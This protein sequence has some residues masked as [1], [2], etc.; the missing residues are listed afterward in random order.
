MACRHDL[1]LW[2]WAFRRLFDSESESLWQCFRILQL[3]RTKSSCRNR[4]SNQCL[5][6]GQYPL[7]INYIHSERR[8]ATTAALCEPKWRNAAGIGSQWRN[9]RAIQLRTKVIPKGPASARNG[10]SQTCTSFYCNANIG[11]CKNW[12]CSCQWVHIRGEHAVFFLCAICYFYSYIAIFIPVLSRTTLIIFFQGNRMAYPLEWNMK[13]I[14]C[15]AANGKRLFKLGQNQLPNF[16]V[17]SSCESRCR[18]RHGAA[19]QLQTNVWTVIS[20]CHWWVRWHLARC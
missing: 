3:L 16:W 10:C 17:R 12:I 7:R 9:R 14:T 20:L 19:V 8:L 15:I 2:I 11:A 1:Q 18:C 4:G 5:P 13:N 6:T